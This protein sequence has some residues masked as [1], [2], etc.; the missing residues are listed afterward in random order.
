[1]SIFHFWADPVDWFVN[2]F[3]WY[4]TSPPWYVAANLLFWPAVFA[5]AWLHDRWDLHRRRRTKQRVV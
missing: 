1:M 4:L 2:Q 5:K 3:T